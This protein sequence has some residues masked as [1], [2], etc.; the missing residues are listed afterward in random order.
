[1][2]FNA[3]VLKCGVDGDHILA[4]AVEAAL[5]VEDAEREVHIRE[6]MV[7]IVLAQ[8]RAQARGVEAAIIFMVLLIVD[9]GRSVASELWSGS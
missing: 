3:V 2:D 4:D 8:E 5:D 7:E 6:R 1:M 9:R